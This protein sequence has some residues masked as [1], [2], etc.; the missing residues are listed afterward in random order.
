MTQQKEE[1]TWAIQRLATS[2][3]AGKA[4]TVESFLVSKLG[5]SAGKRLY[6]ELLTLAKDMTKS[7]VG[8]PAINLTAKGG[9]FVAAKEI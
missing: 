1:I 4:T 7:V 2:Q 8:S 5:V 9:E 6:K 3:D